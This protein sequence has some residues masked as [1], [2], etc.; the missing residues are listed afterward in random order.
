[1]KKTKINFKRNNELRNQNKL[2][3]KSIRELRRIQA[4]EE[5]REETM[6]QIKT[7]REQEKEDCIDSYDV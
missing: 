7:R 5:T 6:F 1:M 3:K 4:K 2:T